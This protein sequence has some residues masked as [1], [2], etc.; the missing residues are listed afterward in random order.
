MIDRRRLV[1]FAAASVLAPAIPCRA[2][3]QN[4]SPAQG[5]PNRVVRLV[6]PFAPAGGVDIVGR[7][8]A[9]R[10][11]EMW[12]QQ[13][14]VENRGGAGGNIAAEMVARAAPDGYTMFIASIG[15]AINQYMFP[16]L[17]YDPVG[18]FAPVTLI[19]IYPNVMVVP[20]SSP[21]HSVQEFIAYAKANRG[22]VSFASSSS[23][24][25]VHLAGELFKRA[26]GIEMTHVPYR[27]AGPAYNDLIP[28]RV[29]V[30]FATASSAV[31]QVRSGTLRGLAV[32]TMRRLAIVPD[33]PTLD[34]SGL[35]GFDVS[36]WFAFFVPART[37]PE[38]I[39]KINADTT[40][41]LRDAAIVQKI[42]QLGASIVAST[43]DELAAHLKREMEK[44][45]PVVRD[46]QI[47]VLE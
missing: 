35:P 30:M 40:S 24:T 25:S 17:G 38:I 37:P 19:C 42:E 26:V 44:W 45:G 6:V 34:E 15:H 32:T 28:G 12:D 4:Q 31:P 14:V 9:A 20:N 11:S 2:L 7:I 43:P 8:L 16:S 21:A 18:D 23:G 39:A 47:K 27:G 3:A 41:V 10:L 33:L 36:S 5:W 1:T 29:D 22:K 13:I 46:A